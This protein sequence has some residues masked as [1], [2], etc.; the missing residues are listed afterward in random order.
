[1]SDIFLNWEDVDFNWE[2]IQTEEGNHN[3]L[4]WEDVDLY[5]M[6]INMEWSMIED[7]SH[8]MNWE[9]IK[10]IEEVSRTVRGGG[11][12]DDYLK[13]DNPWKKLSEDIGEEKTERFIKI[14]CTVNGMD[15]EKEIQLNESV[16]VSVDR[17]E[18][19]FEKIKIKVDVKK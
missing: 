4:N 12:Y 13:K 10:L 2:S 18:K 7:Y 5:W 3:L 1:M 6:D 11:G 16:T 19:V 9:D 17:F 14:Y 8:F 15:Y